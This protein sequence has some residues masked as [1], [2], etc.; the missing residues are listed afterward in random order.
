MDKPSTQNELT[1]VDE[2][3]EVAQENP[4]A[5]NLFYDAFL[6]ADIYVPALR[7]NKKPGEW[8]Q[9]SETERFF[10]L[11][12]HHEENRAVP[13]FDRLDKLKTWAETKAF[14]YL[15]IKAHL[16]IK[17]IAPEIA[18]VL[19]EGTEHR[20]LFIPEILEQLRNALK[21]VQVN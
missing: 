9:I 8:S 19:N 7:A 10:P 21:N 20:Y 16:F 14:D 12:L 6:N 13:V 17:V 5:A 3:L 18:V 2:A 15:K 11:Y 1:E 4:A